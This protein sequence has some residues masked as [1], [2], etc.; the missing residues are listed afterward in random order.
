MRAATVFVGFLNCPPG[1]HNAFLDW[2]EDDHRPEN[3]GGIEH[4]YHSPRFIAPPDSLRYRQLGC[5]EPWGDAGQYLMT[6]WSSASPERLLEDM[7]TLRERLDG[8]GRCQPINRDFHAVWRDRMRV[9]GGFA[10]PRHL[11]SRSPDAAPFAP[12]DALVVTVGRYPDDGGRWARWY[13]TEGLAGIFEDDRFTA[14]FTLSPMDSANQS[15][16]VHLHYARG[17]A[18]EAPAALRSHIEPGP[19]VLFRAVYLPQH[20]GQPRFYQ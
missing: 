4:I 15:L 2:H 18:E 8:L 19:E 10:N 17:M 14:A 5:E 16:F 9:V 7:T 6:Y 20:A 13:E 3:H 12:H 11:V 1:H